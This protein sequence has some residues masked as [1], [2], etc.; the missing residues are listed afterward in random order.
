VFGEYCVASC[1]DGPVKI[2]YNVANQGALQ[3]SSPVPVSL[4]TVDQGVET[5]MDTHYHLPVPPGQSV[6]GNIFEIHPDQWGSGFIIRVDDDGTG[7]GVVEECDE[8]NNEYEYY[9]TLCY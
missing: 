8:T 2:S 3:A 5:L 1:T 7:H 9:E 4:F 6:Y